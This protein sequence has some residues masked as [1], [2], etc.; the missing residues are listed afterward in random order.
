MKPRV[1]RIEVDIEGYDKEAEWKSPRKGDHV[2]DQF[3]KIIKNLDIDYFKTYPCIIIK[4]INKSKVPG[5]PII[6]EDMSQTC[7]NCSNI[8]GIYK[9]KI[10]DEFDCGICNTILRITPEFNLEEV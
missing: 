4:P 2:I 6:V 5:E 9:P 8:V 10:G 3:G 7:P 1:T